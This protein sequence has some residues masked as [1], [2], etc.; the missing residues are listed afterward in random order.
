MLVRVRDDDGG[1]FLLWTSG[2]SSIEGGGDATADVMGGP[3]M[4]GAGQLAGVDLPVVESLDIELNLGLNGKLTVQV[5]APY[6]LGLRMLDS[7]LF[8]IG[9]VIEAQLGYPRSG[10]FTPW[11]S[12]MAAQPAIR[13]S[14]DDGLVATL[15]GEGGAFASLRSSSNQVYENQSYRQV[16]QAV[17]DRHRWTTSFPEEDRE[18]ALDR[19]RERVSQAGYS[20]WGY[21]N[22]LCRQANVDIYMGP[23]P[24]ELGRS[25]LFVRRRR[26]DHE[27]VPRRSYVMRRQIDMISVFPILDYETDSLGVWLPRSAESVSTGD[28]VPE[29]RTIQRETVSALTTELAVLNEVSMS[30]TG[31]AV[32][33]DHL[34][35]AFAIRRSQLDTGEHLPLSARDPSRRPTEVAQAHRDEGAMRGSLNATVTTFG[36]PEQLPGELVAIRGVGRLDG[37]FQVHGLVHR[38]MPGEWTMTL[39]CMNNGTATDLIANFFAVQPPSTNREEPPEATVNDGDGGGTDV[40][41][42]PADASSSTGAG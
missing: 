41:A 25:R 28:I 14:P 40:E 39:T 29:D 34:A 18:T 21:I 32:I 17:A 42:V 37:T 1:S 33:G 20:D 9:N 23:D 19:N 31:S 2:G 22:Q 3:A 38:A 16:I 27:A 10:R 36:V 13:I 15:N 11:F 26:E 7:T 5:A 12:A 6:D 4:A 24:E 35:Q 8:K 30:G